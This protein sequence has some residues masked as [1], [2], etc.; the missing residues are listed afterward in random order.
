[1]RPCIPVLSGVQQP[2]GRLGQLEDLGPRPHQLIRPAQRLGRP[3][4]GEPLLEHGAHRARLAQRRELLAHDVLRRG[5]G[6]R[7]LVIGA[8]VDLDLRLAQATTC[9][10]SLVSGDER[11]ALAAGTDRQRLDHPEHANRRHQP[12]DVLLVDVAFSPT[13]I[14]ASDTRVRLPRPPWIDR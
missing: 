7:V 4:E 12:R 13:S 14:I 1:M 2:R 5:D 6:R 10:V 9:L 8:N 3:L 11:V